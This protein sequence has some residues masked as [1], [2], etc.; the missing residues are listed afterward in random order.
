MNRIYI[1]IVLAVLLLLCLFNMPYGYYTFV[2]FVVSI[3]FAIMAYKSYVSKETEWCIVY[4]A[5]AILFQP[6][7]KIP[8]GRVMWNIV[9]VLVAVLLFVPGLLNHF[10]KID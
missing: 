5:I 6:I 8:L 9:D 4:V 7:F 2:R 10:N 1:K 3:A